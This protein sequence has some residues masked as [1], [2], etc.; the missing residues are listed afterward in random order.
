MKKTFFCVLTFQIEHY[1]KNVIKDKTKSGGRVVSLVFVLKCYSKTNTNNK[2]NTF[3][4]KNYFL[5]LLQYDEL[6]KR[7]EKKNWLLYKS[8]IDIN[9]QKN[10]I[11]F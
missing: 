10:E 9:L 2:S 4:E 11:F 1:P 5:V 8:K 3:F 6:N 7:I